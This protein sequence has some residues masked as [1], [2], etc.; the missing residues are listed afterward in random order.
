MKTVWK[1][2]LY[3]SPNLKITM[4]AG[5]QI[6][7]VQNQHDELQLWALVDTEAPFKQRTFGVFETGEFKESYGNHLAT[8]QIRGFVWHVFETVRET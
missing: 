8:V 5:A 7:S 1:Y 3:F 4:P 2:G 6:L